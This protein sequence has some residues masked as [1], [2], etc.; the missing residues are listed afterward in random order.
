MDAIAV[1][2]LSNAVNLSASYVEGSPAL[3]VLFILVT[4]GA[5]GA[6]DFTRSVYL[7][8]DREMSNG[9]MQGAM[10]GGD[11]TVLAFDVEGDG[12]VGLGLRSPAAVES[13]TVQG[14]GL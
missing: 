11:Y 6:V 12:G 14:G 8:L 4:S 10:S 9:F 13:V 2:G 7:V 1:T 5:D 3:G